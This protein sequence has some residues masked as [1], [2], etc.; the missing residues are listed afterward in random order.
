MIGS[1]LSEVW[2]FARFYVKRVQIIIA[3]ENKYLDF[4]VLTRKRGVA[5][6]CWRDNN[7]YLE[8]REECFAVLKSSVDVEGEH[9]RVAEL[10]PLRQLVLR[11]AGKAWAPQNLVA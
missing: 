5:H 4:S 9:P 7:L 2:R 6:L 11:V 8:S 1:A 10:L 3:S